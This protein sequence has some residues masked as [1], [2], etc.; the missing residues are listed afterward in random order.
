M[1]KYPHSGSRGLEV[2][3]H[4]WLPSEFRT[5]LNPIL[6]PLTHPSPPKKKRGRK[7]R[8][9]QAKEPSLKAEM[10]WISSFE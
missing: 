7:V 8:R 4:S 5:S 6:H 3:G 10:S 1:L 9:I 2:Q